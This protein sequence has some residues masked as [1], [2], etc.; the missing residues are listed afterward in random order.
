MPNS[1]HSSGQVLI[2]HSERRGEFGIFPMDNNET[3]A[4]KLK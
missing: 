3:L 1:R 4:I 2:G